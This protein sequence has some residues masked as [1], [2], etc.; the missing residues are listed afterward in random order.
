MKTPARILIL[1]VLGVFA[2]SGSCGKKGGGTGRNEGKGEGRSAQDEQ[3]DG[4]GDAPRSGAIQ[5]RPARLMAMYEEG[6]RFEHFTS[7]VIQG[8]AKSKTWF[9]IE[10]EVNVFLDNAS[11]VR[12]EIVEVT[13]DRVQ[14]RVGVPRIEQQFVVRTHRIRFDPDLTEFGQYVWDFASSE[15]P[16]GVRWAGDL[17]DKL[18]PKAEKLLTF[19]CG[20][21]WGDGLKDRDPY[22]RFAAKVDRRYS[23]LVLRIDYVKD[24]GVTAVHRVS[25]PTISN[26][27]VDTLGR[28]LGSAVF[29]D[30]VLNQIIADNLDEPG[31]KTEVDVTRMLGILGL[32]WDIS[33]TGTVVLERCEDDRGRIVLAVTGGNVRLDAQTESGPQKGLMQPKDGKVYVTQRGMVELGYIEWEA[34]SRFVPSESLLV[35][36]GELREGEFKSYVARRETSENDGESGAR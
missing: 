16:P 19:F 27:V 33:A 10:A 9:G 34:K 24:K 17:L 14:V 12:A 15:V 22:L 31:K 28:R 3:D 5:L 6:E 7:H 11:F 13:S 1:L 20:E 18:D 26:Q 35:Q 25:G 4:E 8:R 21:I 32:P 30:Y 23:G 2:V 36:V 29:V